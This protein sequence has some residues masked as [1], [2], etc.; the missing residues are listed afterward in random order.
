[1]P[2][3]INPATAERLLEPIFKRYG[4]SRAVLFGSAAKGTNNEK[5]DVDIMVDSHLKGL[6]FLGLAQDIQDVI[7][8]PVDLL[9]ITHIEKNSKIYT[10]IQ[11]TGIVIYEK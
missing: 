2:D 11:N 10:E 3:L 4:V 8:T 6:K 1:M 7:K 9:D 5:S